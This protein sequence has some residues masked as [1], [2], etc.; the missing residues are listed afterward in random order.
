MATDEEARRGKVSV[1]P[2]HQMGHEHARPRAHVLTL[3][4][5]TLATLDPAQQRDLV[6]ALVEVVARGGSEDQLAEHLGGVLDRAG[7]PQ[8][9]P[10]VARMAENLRG[11]SEVTIVTDAGQVLHGDEGFDISRQDADV[12]G[13]EDPEDGDRPVYS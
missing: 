2:D 10:V 6:T 9:E 7:V 8:P 3:S 5:T 12:H 4:S 1:M 11:A 13:T